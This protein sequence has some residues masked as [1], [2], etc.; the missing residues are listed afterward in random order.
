MQNLWR[1][2]EGLNVDLTS[3]LRN[4][5]QMGLAYESESNSKGIEQSCQAEQT[6]HDTDHILYS[7]HA[8]YFPISMRHTQ[9]YEYLLWKDGV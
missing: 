2:H 1:I 5:R 6:T 3:V 9:H 4:F 8:K 7:H